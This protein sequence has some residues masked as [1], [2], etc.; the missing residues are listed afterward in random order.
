MYC[1]RKRH[2]IKYVKEKTKEIAEGY[3]CLEENYINS[4]TKLKFKCNKNHKFIMKWSAFQQGCR[5]TEC[6][7]NKK[8]TLSYVKRETK[9]IAKGYKC[10]SDK[11]KN[12][13]NKLTF[14]CDKNH[15][16]KM[17]WNDFK[18]EK[19]CSE[20]AGNRKLSIE[21]VKQKTIELAKGYECL[22]DIYTNSGGKL[23]FKC[24]KGHTYKT[25]WASFQSGNRCP[26]CSKYCNKYTID[27][28]KQ[29]V[30]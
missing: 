21:Y 8:L 24:D 2:S 17:R 5:C 6:A 18:Q 16:F 30:I 23:I 28:I 13:G 4:R 26:M 19:R 15:I 25:I 11:Y 3:K 1:N 9:K 29:K 27:S 7:G 20:C 12:T 22:S 14:L 10:I